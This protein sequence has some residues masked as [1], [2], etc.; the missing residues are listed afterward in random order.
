MKV[1]SNPNR[2][3]DKAVEKTNF[4]TFCERICPYVIITAVFILIV[5]ALYVMTVHGHTVTVTE[6]NAFYNQLDV[7]V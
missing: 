7:M 3:L 2:P 1:I 4:E 6:A 5:L